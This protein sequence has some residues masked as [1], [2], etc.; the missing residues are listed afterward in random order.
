LNPEVEPARVILVDKPYGWTSFQAVKKVKFGLKS[1]KIG[2]AGTLD[3]LATGLLIMCTGKMTK[4]IESIQSQEKEYT[5]TFFLGETTP[6][7][8]LETA[9]D[10]VYPIEHITPKLIEETV[11]TF[12]G[13]TDQTPPLFSAIKVE[14]KRAYDIARKG[15]DAVLKSRKIVIK[16]FEITRLELPEI[17]FRIVCS[18]GTYIRSIARDFGLKLNSGA[19]LKALRRTKIGDYLVENAMHPQD[20]TTESVD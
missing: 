17:D 10:Q 8:D 6:S 1:K 14:G 3:P 16:E 19:Y 2:H 9:T 4:S 18:K 11:L 12:L 7:F 13:E 15:G 20:V 5:G